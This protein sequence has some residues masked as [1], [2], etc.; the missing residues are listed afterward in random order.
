MN[1]QVEEQLSMFGLK[2]T[3]RMSA[4]PLGQLAIEILEITDPPKELIRYDRTI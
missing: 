1:K 4:E 2:P 3:A